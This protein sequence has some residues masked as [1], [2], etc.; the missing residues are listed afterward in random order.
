MIIGIV[1]IAVIFEG[2]TMAILTARTL[3][4]QRFLTTRLWAD[5]RG[6]VRN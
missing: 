5:D 3:T 1:S 2:I 4:S 6:S